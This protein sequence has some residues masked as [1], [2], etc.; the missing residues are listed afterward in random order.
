MRMSEEMIWHL[1]LHVLL[2][3]SQSGTQG[4]ILF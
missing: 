3:G 2:E 4:L 1:G